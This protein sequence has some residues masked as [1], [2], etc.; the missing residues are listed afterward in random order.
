MQYAGRMTSAE[1]IERTDAFLTTVGGEWWRTAVIYQIYPRSFADASGDGIGDLPGITSHLDDLAH[2]GIDAIWLS[3][4]QRS[5]QKDAGYD[6]SDYCDV[7]PLFG[8]LADF[9]D[10]LAAAH[11]RSIRV[12]VDLVP[13]HSSDQHEWFQQ[14][15]AAAPHSAERA[16]YMFRD[17]KGRNGELPPNNWE[18]VF[19]GPAWTRV[20]EADGEPGQWYLH[21]FDSSQ[22]DFDWSNEEVREE[23]R[24]ILR[25]WLDRGVDGFRVDVAHGLVKAEG[26]PDYIPNPEAGSMGGEA[27]NVP[28]WGQDAVHEVYRDWRKILEEYEGH[29]ALAAEAWLPTAAR[30]AEWVRSDEMHQAFN[31]PYLE[32]KWN[33][34]DLREVIDVSLD[35]FPGVGAPSTWVLSNHDVVR[36]ASRLAL[37]AENP[38]GHGIGPDS[39][40]QPIREVGLA[41]ARAATTLMLALPGSAYLYQ[42]E[43]L[44]LPEVIDIPGDARQDPTWF[45]TNGE[46]YG[47]DGC[48][49]P[50]PWNAD[51]PAYGFNETGASWLPQ[52]AEWATLARDVQ[53]GVEGSTLELYRTLLAER[54]ERSLG[55]GSL[56]WIDGYGADAVAFRNG[57]VTVVANTGSTPIALPSGIVIASSGPVADGELPG[58]TTVWIHTA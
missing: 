18:S 28:Y 54:R 10:M 9:D 17:G 55:A 30:T 38:Q 46:R 50:I 39:P 49:V 13:N 52:P 58:D 32:T 56:E 34:A 23:F 57:N 7:D 27:E 53:T 12:I 16:R 1:T 48:R 25:F 15:L 44:G 33:A 19:G 22:P 24:R 11:G 35:A 41:R 8:T 29:R 20:V 6:V 45:R 43:E 5:P 2:L 40:G 31:F 14:A 4:F 21:L 3:P 36:H 37:T 47:R 51:A 26:L 42:G